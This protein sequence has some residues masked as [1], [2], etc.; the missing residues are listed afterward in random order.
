[1]PY[2]Y[3]PQILEELARHGLTPRP[4]TPPGRL[5]DAVR[6]LY[7]CRIKRLRGA[8]LAGAFPKGDYANRVVELRKKY[9]LLSIP[10]DLW[11]LGGGHGKE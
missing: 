7:K 4:S 9:P 6:D 1:M 8:L 11:T 10:T 5:R 3:H 2:S